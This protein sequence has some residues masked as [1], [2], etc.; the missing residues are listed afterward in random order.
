MITKI[1]HQY[2]KH[3]HHIN[4]IYD[5]HDRVF[6]HIPKCG[7]WGIWN[8]FKPLSSFTDQHA[9]IETYIKN[10]GLEF[11]EKHKV[12]TIVRNPF[13]R[14]VSW[15]FYHKRTD[16]NN[17]YIEHTFIEW[18]KNGCR[19]HWDS[20]N[21]YSLF[22]FIQ[23]NW[24]KYNNEIIVPQNRIF[25]LEE[26]GKY[27]M[28]TH[29]SIRNSNCYYYYDKETKKYIEKLCEEDFNNFNYKLNE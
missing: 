29:Y 14:M 21:P 10:K 27:Y 3:L 28:R 20:T 26:I 9:T 17:I 16:T 23:S 11:L 25:K 22:P 8:L 6:I 15:F 19:N 7:G 24:L 5:F 18:V 4:N 1:N 12:F 2:K 13:D